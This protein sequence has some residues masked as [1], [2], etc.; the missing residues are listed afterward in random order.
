MDEIRSNR[1]LSAEGLVCYL[2][3]KLIPEDY[4]AVV[5]L[6][7]RENAGLSVGGAL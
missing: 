1:H 7:G 2:V 4:L 6:L 5:L 3:G